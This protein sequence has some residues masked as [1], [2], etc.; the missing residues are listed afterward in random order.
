MTIETVLLR[1]GKREPLSLFYRAKLRVCLWMNQRCQMRDR[2]QLTAITGLTRVKRLRSFD[3]AND[4]EYV[5]VEEA[6]VMTVG[7]SLKQPAN[8]YARKIFGGDAYHGLDGE[9]ALGSEPRASDLCRSTTSALTT[10]EGEPDLF[11]WMFDLLTERTISLPYAERYLRMLERLDNLNDRRLRPV[12]CV[13][14]DSADGVRELD[15]RWCAEGYEGSIVRRAASL[16]KHGRSTVTKGEVLRIKTFVEDEAEII[17]YE[18]GSKNMNEAKVDALGHI[19]R[20]THQENM[21]PNG[22]IGTMYGKVLTGMFKGDTIAIA[23]G[24]MTVEEA[25]YLFQNPKALLGRISKFKHFPKGI[26]DRPRYATHQ[27]FRAAFD[28]SE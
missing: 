26:K 2:D 3:Y 22:Q 18:E 24:K 21:V 12:P 25:I 8:L 14:V 5:W 13:T 23:P 16:Y 19:E 15:A 1:E 10:I 7:R 6:T 11:W 17:G 4:P 9:V 28:M 20:S 27:L